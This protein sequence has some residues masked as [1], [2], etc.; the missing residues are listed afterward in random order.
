MEH[1]KRG[2]AQAFIATKPLGKGWGE[3]GEEQ[4]GQEPAE[5]LPAALVW[6]Q[7]RAVAS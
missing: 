7:R 2:G 4:E 5:K 3:A 6:R 1:N